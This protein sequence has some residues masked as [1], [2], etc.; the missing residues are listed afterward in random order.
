MDWGLAISV[1]ATGKAERLMTA[2]GAAG[3]RRGSRDGGPFCAPGC[4]LAEER[5]WVW[6]PC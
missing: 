4:G 2:A 3:W 6:H 1:S 5:R